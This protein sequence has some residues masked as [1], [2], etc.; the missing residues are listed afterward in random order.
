GVV[1]LGTALLLSRD[2]HEVTVLERDAEAPPVGS[3][4]IWEN[5]QRRGVNQFRLPHFF[6][7]RYRSLL[8]TELPD[9]AE[10]L[11][12][13]GAVRL[14]TVLDAPETVRGPVRDEDGAFECI[15]G[16]R[17]VVEAAV[18]SVAERADRLEIRR[19]ATVAGL[20]TGAAARDGIPHVAGV[21]LTTGEEV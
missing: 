16:R 20:V 17:C 8:G 21:R 18:A 1:G 5:W 12:D 14:N 9:V 19:E 10:A 4:E 7:A 13:A 2:G 11:T 6:L 3:D 15:S